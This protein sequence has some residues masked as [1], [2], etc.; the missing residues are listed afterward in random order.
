MPNV[1]HIWSTVPWLLSAVL[2]LAF[3]HRGGQ[4]HKAQREVA[5]MRE[6]EQQVLHD[7]WQL[8]GHYRRLEVERQQL[9]RER[10]E[11]EQRRQK[12]LDHTPKDKH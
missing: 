11:Q 4:L 3:V 10:R 7:K 12:E 5:E 6:Q 1:K 8:A 2:A 9:A